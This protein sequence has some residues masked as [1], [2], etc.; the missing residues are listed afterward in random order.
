[1]KYLTLNK[2]LDYKAGIISS[3]LRCGPFYTC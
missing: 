2:Q 1:M 3:T